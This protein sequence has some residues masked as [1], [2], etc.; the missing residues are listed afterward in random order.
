MRIPFALV[1]ILA[2]GLIAA[3]CGSSG[4]TTTK[5]TTVPGGHLGITVIPDPKPGRFAG[6][7]GRHT[8]SFDF[9]GK[10]ITNYISDEYK[11]FGPIPF[12]PG[13]GFEATSTDG[14][15]YTEAST[16]RGGAWVVSM[17]YKGAPDNPNLNWQMYVDPVK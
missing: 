5:T 10:Q 13:S 1:T 3:G 2:I 6:K 14:K 4:S 16:I 17:K 12:R 11:R 8:M 7:E 9:D 15:W